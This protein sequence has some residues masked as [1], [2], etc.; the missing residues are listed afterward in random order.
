MCTKRKL[1]Q[2][3]QNNFVMF[4]LEYL[5]SLVEQVWHKIL[6]HNFNLMHNYKLFRTHAYH[7][8]LSH[9]NHKNHLG[10]M[11]GKV[12]TAK[13]QCILNLSYNILNQP[14]YFFPPQTPQHT[15]RQFQPQI[16]TNQPLPLP[17][18][19]F[20]QK[21]NQLPTQPL[22]SSNNT[23]PQQPIYNVKVQ[24]FQAYM[25]SPLDLNDVQ[26]YIWSSFIK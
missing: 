4:L 10:H 5:G 7:V 26:L 13:I 12:L 17:S 23:V 3:K 22:P 11:D 16:T 25:I 6:M 18:T 8:K 21:S 9:L 1:G 24:N 2:V 20:P 19:S 14:Q 15:Q